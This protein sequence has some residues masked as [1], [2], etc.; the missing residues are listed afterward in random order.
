MFANVSEHLRELNVLIKKK[1]F[2][3][4][5]TKGIKTPPS[6]LQV[7]IFMYLLT[8]KDEDICQK[9]LEMF[10]KV[11][12]VAISEALN[13]MENNGTIKRIKMSDDGRSKKIIYTKDAIKKMNVMEE[14]LVN[15]NK[16]L[17]ANITDEELQVFLKVVDQMKEN[18]RKDEDNV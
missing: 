16:L 3:I 6:P 18:I 12:K 15:L 13:K 14:T 8:H 4:G 9:D 10:L 7:R 17:V 2:T 1:L 5:S 11:S